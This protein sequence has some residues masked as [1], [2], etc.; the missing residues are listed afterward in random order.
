[1]YNDY[2]RCG[3]EY[4]SKVGPKS[5]QHIIENKW[6]HDVLGY[7]CIKEGIL[8]VGLKIEGEYLNTV[9]T[10]VTE[11][12]NEKVENSMKACRME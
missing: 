7:K 8:T 10:Y 12:G 2:S 5:E 6:R 9:V 3:V 1:M 11:E 4:H